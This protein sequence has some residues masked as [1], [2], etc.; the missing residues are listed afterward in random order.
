MADA[1]LPYFWR[2][3]K[4]LPERRGQPCRILARGRLGSVLVEFADGCRV[5]TSRYAV[6]KRQASAVDPEGATRP[7]Q[8]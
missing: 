4:R 7:G 2:W 1:P 3:R 6:R 8:D 5:V